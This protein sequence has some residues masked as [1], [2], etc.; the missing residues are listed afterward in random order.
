MLSGDLFY[1]STSLG[2]AGP[3]VRRC[4]IGQALHGKIQ[5]REGKKSKEKR[6]ECLLVVVEW[7]NSYRGVVQE[8]CVEEQARTSKGDNGS[9]K[10][11]WDAIPLRAIRNGPSRRGHKSPRLG[12]IFQ[13]HVEQ[14]C[15]QFT[16]AIGLETAQVRREGEVERLSCRM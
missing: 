7:Q 13:T 3:Q 5:I 16:C 8:G 10:S 2:N 12:F 11:S 9:R 1:S 15:P 6:S 4:S 14:S